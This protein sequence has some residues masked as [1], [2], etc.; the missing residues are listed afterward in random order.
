MNKKRFFLA[1]WL[2]FAFVMVPFLFNPEPTSAAECHIIKVNPGKLQ[3]PVTIKPDALMV[4]PGDCVVWFN[5]SAELI[6]ITFKGSGDKCAS[7]AGFFKAKECFVTSWYDNGSTTSM[8][9]ME[10]GTYEYE[11]RAKH[12]EVTKVLG[13]IIVQ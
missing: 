12:E 10:K 3:Q 8:R 13:K 9:L 4:S 5:N 2:S 1:I 11:I 6:K 7:P